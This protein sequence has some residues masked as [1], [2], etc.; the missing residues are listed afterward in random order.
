MLAVGAPLR[1]PRTR[2]Q[3]L[4]FLF[5]G[6]DVAQA[7]ISRL[8]SER[9]IDHQAVATAPLSVD[10]VDGTILAFPISVDARDAVI[11]VVAEEGGRLVADVPEEWTVTRPAR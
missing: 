10:N 3:I 7:A 9:W 5:A 2:M 4:A 1:S 8:R 11:A 6:G